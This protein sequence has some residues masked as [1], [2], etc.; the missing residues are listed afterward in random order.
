VTVVLDMNAFKVPPEMLEVRRVTPHKIRK[1]RQHWT[2]LPMAWYEPMKGASGQTCRVAWYLL[3]LH[4]KNKGQ[5]FKLSNGMLR[6][7]GV[8][9]RSKWRA[10]RDLEQ[11]GLITVECRPKRAPIVTVHVEPRVG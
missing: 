5:P 7:D 8:S 11:C 3:Y 2:K 1:R 10:L 6:E 9:P 4:W